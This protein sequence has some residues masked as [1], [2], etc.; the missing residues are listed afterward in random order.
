[1][2]TD[3]GTARGSGA[4]WRALQHE[5]ARAR[6]DATVVDVGGGSGVWAVPLAAA[7]CLVTVVEPNPNALATLRLRAQEKGVLD[8]ITV[9]ADDTDSLGDRVPAGSA[10]LVLAHGL[11]EVVDDP[12][13][14]VTALAA[15]AAPGAAVSVL[16]ANRYAA[17]LHRA[18]TGRLAQ[19]RRLL[20]GAHGVLDDDGENL[21]RRFDIPGLQSLLT[22][23]GLE[24]E[25]LQGDGVVSDSLGE[26][27][28]E[29]CTSDELGEFEAAAGVVPPL[30]DIASRIHALARRP[31]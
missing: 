18:L 13:P 25:L 16:A 9:V 10:D 21:L 6:P 27:E 17:V 22:A 4:V 29:L 23:A 12:G 30:R 26:A 14:V 3:T 31:S 8:R 1:M 28:S 15:A 20:T 24:V 5:L 19:A 7:G 11:L 2:W